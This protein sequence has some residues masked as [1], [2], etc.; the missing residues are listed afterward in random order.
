V[1][2]TEYA[3]ELLSRSGMS[4]ANAAF[5]P[6]PGTANLSPALQDEDVLNPVDHADYRS[7]I[8][9]LL[10]LSVCTRPDLAFPVSALARHLH[11]PTPRHAA[12]LKR[13]LRYLAGSLSLGLHY[14]FTDSCTPSSLRAF[15]DADW[16]GCLDSR[17]STTGFVITVNDAPVHWRSKRQTL[18]SLS[19][20]NSEYIA[21]SSCGQ[22]LTWIRRLFW[23]IANQKPWDDE[24]TFAATAVAV[25]STAAGAIATDAQISARNKH[26]EIKTHHVREMIQNG[27][28]ELFYVPT[29]LQAADVLT[30]IVPAETLQRM[31]QL[32]YLS[33]F[34]VLM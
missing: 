28:I 12:L 8:G 13:L 6:L 10:Y 4:T 20:A 9:G 2:Q 17:K 21:L 27:L 33:D 30:K 15:A 7:T 11:A 18:I 26:I 16:G 32:L 25:D 19:S 14:P 31:I 29:K 22:V 5:T 34:P 23:E 3:K 24:V 1:N